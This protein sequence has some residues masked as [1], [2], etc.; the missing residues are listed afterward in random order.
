[1]LPCPDLSTGTP[2]SK[3]VRPLILKRSDRSFFVRIGTALVLSGILAVPLVKG[4]DAVGAGLSLLIVE[5]GSE[6]LKVSFFDGPLMQ[7][8]VCSR[9][10]LE[11]YRRGRDSL[12]GKVNAETYNE[13]WEGYLSP[14]LSGQYIFAVKSAG[15]VRILLKNKVI[16]ET[17]AMQAGRRT[18]YR[19]SK[20][21]D[22]TTYPFRVE[23]SPFEGNVGFRV[24]WTGPGVPRN[25]LLQAPFLMKRPVSIF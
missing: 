21:F 2:I 5:A 11:L 23:Y 12:P 9:T 10:Y 22:K 6:G 19:F 4:A 14:P 20:W 18:I 25:S 1:V 7:K 3:K 24:D 15:H 17:P 8:K 16:F 13:L